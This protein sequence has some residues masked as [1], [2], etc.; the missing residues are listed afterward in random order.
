[1]QHTD[2]WRR[3][4]DLC[5]F[6]FISILQAE[7]VLMFLNYRGDVKLITTKMGYANR[8]VI[9]N[10]LGR[11]RRDNGLK[12]NIHMVMRLVGR[13]GFWNELDCHLKVHRDQLKIAKQQ[14]E[15]RRQAFTKRRK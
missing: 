10:K 14:V 9:D 11:F 12:N 6:H 2:E 8:V 15:L 7:I 13:T 3:P 1:M 4:F 5:G